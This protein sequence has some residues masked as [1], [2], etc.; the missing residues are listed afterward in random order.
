MRVISGQFRGRPL[1][2]LTGSVTRPT[3]GR[4]REAVFNILQGRVLE[5]RWLDLCAGSGAMAL[6]ALSRGAKEAVLIEN[7]P[8]AC[9]VIRANIQDLGVGGVSR[10]IQGDAVWGISLLAK[11]GEPFDLIYIDPPYQQE[12]T[13]R[14][15][16]RSAPDLLVSGGLFMVEHPPG[17]ILPVALEL[18]DSRRYGTAQISFFRKD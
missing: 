17:F 2:T 9:Q 10:L 13:Y 12:Q 11:E 16:L 1:K 15:L 5:S 7:N 14:A 6:E 3:T 18:I 8:R 4:V